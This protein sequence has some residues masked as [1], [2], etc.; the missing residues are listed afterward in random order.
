MFYHMSPEAW[1]IPKALSTDI[2]F[3]RCLSSMNSLMTCKI[4]IMIKTLATHITFIR[5]LS[6]MS[7]P[8]NF[9]VWISTKDL[10]TEVTFMQF[11]SCMDYLMST[12]VWALK[13]DFSTLITFVRSFPVCYLVL[14][15]YWR[16]YKITPIYIRNVGLA[17]RRNFLRWWWKWRT[18]LHV[19]ISL[20]KFINCLSTLKRA[21]CI[22]R[23][24]CKYI[25][26][27]LLFCI[28]ST[29]LNSSISDTFIMECRDISIISFIISPLTPEVTHTFL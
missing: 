16:M 17:R 8:M 22:P 25:C 4:W 14:C 29:G 27:Q 1:G 28:L 24:W 19:V 23:A 3:V 13:K 5:F 6:S 18:T 21:Q 20:M 26:N 10:S 15:Q 2:A 12:E 11:L 7:S 9:K